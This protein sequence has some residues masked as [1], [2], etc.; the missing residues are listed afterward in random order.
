MTI[1]CSRSPW[2]ALTPSC[3]RDDSDIKSGVECLI[4]DIGEL[5][6]LL[7]GNRKHFVGKNASYG[8]LQHRGDA[9]C[10]FC[11]VG[12]RPM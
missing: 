11:E 8:W 12:C 2:S 3:P 5:D 10:A 1:R 4:A 6:T 7:T 9:R